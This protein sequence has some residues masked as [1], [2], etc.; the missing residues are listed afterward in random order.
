MPITRRLVI[1]AGSLALWS[2][3]ARAQPGPVLAADDSL[4]WIRVDGQTWL[5]GE[6]S[7]G[8][9]IPAAVQSLTV[10]DAQREVLVRLE[11]ERLLAA[12]ADAKGRPARTL[13]L[14]AGDEMRFF[15]WH[16]LP[17]TQAAPSSVQV[18]CVLSG[19]KAPLSIAL[20]VMA[21]GTLQPPLRG[22]PWVA[23]YDP[24]MP[25]GHRRAAF[26][27][28]GRRCIPARFAIDWIR[29]DAQGRPWAGA[30]RKPFEHWHGWGQEVLAVAD[31]QIVA[32]RDGRDDVMASD[33][34][35]ARWTDDDVSGNF[36]GLGLA[37][38]RVAFYEHL[39]R[40]SIA[41]RLGDR[42]KAG[43]VIARVGRSGVN[44]SGPHLHF[45]VADAPSTLHAQ[46][47]PYVL[48]EFQRRGGY[49]GMEEAHGG[50]P[51][52]VA[53]DA[54]ARWRGEM[55]APNSVVVFD[56]AGRSG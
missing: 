55:P 32:V 8:T 7:V 51:W 35:A 23:V 34:P 11:G 54:D 52:A 9:G 19:A 48:S 1:S 10:A 18:Q 26:V 36:I 31:G 28:E 24:G 44:S 29:L 2:A 40:G 37:D 49:G 12:T 46:G 39:Q 3:R 42:V 16:G 43:Q 41:V 38:S 21:P 15:I 30:E 20:P 17:A 56:E 33:L 25:F 53:A 27:R 47:R 45:H 22:G 14:A 6:L 4:S 5:V 13:E 50:K